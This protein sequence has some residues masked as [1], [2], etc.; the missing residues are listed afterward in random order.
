M[1]SK[2]PRPAPLGPVPGRPLRVPLRVLRAL[3]GRHL[4]PHLR[5]GLLQGRGLVS[6]RSPRNLLQKLVRLLHAHRRLH[7]SVEAHCGLEARYHMP[8]PG[9][10]LEYTKMRA[11]AVVEALHEA[12]AAIDMPLPEGRVSHVAWGCFM[13]LKWAFGSDNYSRRQAADPAG[14]SSKTSSAASGDKAWGTPTKPRHPSSKHLCRKTAWFK[15]T[16][17]NMLFDLWGRP[18]RSQKR[19]FARWYVN[20]EGVRRQARTVAPGRAFKIH[21]STRGN[22][23]GSEPSASAAGRGAIGDAITSEGVTT[24]CAPSKRVGAATGTTSDASGSASSVARR[25]S[26]TALVT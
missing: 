7:L 19:F 23:D 3:A 26:P 10:A 16:T 24:S 20:V 18:M 9:Q 17:K 15:S 11:L 6:A 22:G 2:R 12:A 1:F 13:P 25:P 5:L 14:A 21:A 8:L 4:P